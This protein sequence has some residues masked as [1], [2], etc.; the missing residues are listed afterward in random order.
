MTLALVVEVLYSGMVSGLVID[1]E[2]DA[3]SIDM[4]DIQVLTPNYATRPSLY[5]AVPAPDAMVADLEARGFRATPRL[6][7]GGLAASGESS[8]GV[9][10]LGADPTRDAEVL[11]L[12]LYVARGEWLSDD[13]PLGV[14]VGRGLARTLDVGLG[15]EIVVLSQA[16]DGSM[17]NELFRVRGILM[18]VAA[19]TDRSTILMP[20]QTFRELMVFE[21]GAHKILVRR[22]VGTEL[23]AAA[24]QVMAV[25]T[26]HTSDPVEVKTWKQLNPF[27]AQYIDTVSGAIVIVFLIIYMAVAILILNAMLMAVYERIREIGVLK[28]I[29]YGPWQVL[30]MM[31]IEGLI[32]ALVAT[33][34]GLVLAAPGMWYLA[35]YG[36]DVGALGGMEMGGLTMPAVWK[37]HFAVETTGVPVFLLFFIVMAAVLFPAVKAAWISP[38]QAMHHQ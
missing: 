5:E 38:V 3:V 22:P 19:S 20:S 24:G 11:D 15:D 4:G 35:T 14:V 1:M 13:D 9:V 18:S 28:A 34:I 27:L 26:A 36:I 25:A 2:D 32:Q 7:A 31:V 37:A 6:F 30:A 17:A 12:H 10:F 8:A 29:G 16:A 23:D 33:S 21:E